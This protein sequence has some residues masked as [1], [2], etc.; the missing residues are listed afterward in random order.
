SFRTHL[1]GSPSTKISAYEG[2]VGGF[3]RSFEEIAVHTV[4]VEF[5]YLATWMAESGI[6][7]KYDADTTKTLISVQPPAPI[8]LGIANGIEVAIA[9]FVFQSHSRDGI[10]LRDEAQLVLRESGERS[11][12]DFENLIYGFQ[13]LLTLAV[14]EPAPPTR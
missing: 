5:D 11:Y 10:V 7:Q 12:S 6:D 2:V 1:P 4:N 14:G 13:S 3:Y 8:N 9:P